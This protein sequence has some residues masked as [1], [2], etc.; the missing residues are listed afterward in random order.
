MAILDFPL[1]PAQRSRWQHATHR[2]TAD[3]RA[4]ILAAQADFQ[5]ART[6]GAQ[7][8]YLRLLADL[9]RPITEARL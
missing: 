6:S 8:R 5:A 4:Q 9:I 3:R 1:R 2:L 7:L